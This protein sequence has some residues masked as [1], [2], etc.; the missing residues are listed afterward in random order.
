VKRRILPLLIKA[1]P[2]CGA[3]ADA[4]FALSLV[5]ET[6]RV[7]NPKIVVWV[8]TQTAV[9]WIF[10]G[11]VVGTLISMLVELVADWLCPEKNEDRRETRYQDSTR[12]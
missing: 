3:L 10:I 5:P 8:S 2:A 6:A 12:V 11:S 1:L 7:P 9:V 4:A